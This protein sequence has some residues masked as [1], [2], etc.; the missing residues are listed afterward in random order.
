M[1]KSGILAAIAVLSC[2]ILG[3]VSSPRV[4]NLLHTGPTVVKAH[5]QWASSAGTVTQQV[6]VADVIVRARVLKLFKPQVFERLLAD[7]SD[8]FPTKFSALPFT[9]AL[10][11]VEKVYSGEVHGNIRIVQTGGVVQQ[12]ENHPDLHIQLYDDP[13][14]VEGTDHV[15]FLQEIS[16]D[17]V[18]APHRKLYRIVNSAGRYD[19]TG[20]LVLSYSDLPGKRPTKLI[21]LEK[22]IRSAS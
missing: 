6:A 4:L 7:P 20:S 12:T 10:L 17:P 1:K 9:E 15:F 21:D 3:W 2:F 5:A 8:R 18:L 19:V 13:L 22:E 14:L 16:G 11:K